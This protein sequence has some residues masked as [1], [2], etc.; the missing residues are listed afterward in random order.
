MPFSPR[1]GEW[2]GGRKELLGAWSFPN[3]CGC[4]L[5]SDPTN[6]KEMARVTQPVQNH[7]LWP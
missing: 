3:I 5:F 2:V 6:E 7:L 1:V 4:L